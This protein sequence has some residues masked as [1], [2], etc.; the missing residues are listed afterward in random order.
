ME[1]DSI[2]LIGAICIVIGFLIGQLASSFGNGNKSDPEDREGGTLLEVRRDLK[3]DDIMVKLE[4][5]EHE[6]SFSLDRK[7]RAQLHEI[8]IE[9]NNWLE[10]SP[11]LVTKETQTPPPELET[12]EESKSRPRFN[13]VTMLVNALQADVQKSKLPTESFV[14][15]IDEVLQ[16]LLKEAANIKDP[17]R[18]MEWPGKGMV[19]MVGLEKYDSVDDIPDEGIKNIIRAAVKSWEEQQTEETM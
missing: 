8:I 11:P 18:L 5:K 6:K 10:A 12:P 4:G 15:Q 9:L 17:V 7:Q 19:F 14:E 13:P 16:D 3:S 2:I 1:I